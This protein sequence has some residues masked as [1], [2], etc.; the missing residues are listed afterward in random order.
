VLQLTAPERTDFRETTRYEEV[1]SLMRAASEASPLIH[2]T[3]FGYSFEGRSLPLAVVGRVADASPEAVRASGKTVVY[4]QGDIHA[5]EVEGKEV[6]LILL[7]EIAE[8]MHLP[9]LDSIVILVAP[10]LNAD[11]NERVALTNRGAQHGP[12]G[13]TGTRANAQDLN[14]NRDHM[15]LDSPEGR[16]FVR[17]LVDYDPQL[18]ADLHTTNGTE[19]GYHLT[20]APPLHPNTDPSI[21]AIARDRIFPEMTARVRGA[22]GWEFY[23]YG[24]LQG[25]GENRGWATFDYRPRFNNNYLGLRNRI[26]LLSEAYSYAT[27]EDRMTATRHFVHETLRFASAHA[28]EIR[29]LVA[30]ADAASIVGERLAVRAALERSPEPVEILLGRVEEEVN[31]YSGAI[32]RR[33]TDDVRVERM[34]EFGTFGG[35]DWET[36]PRAYYVPS[37]L[38]EV[39]RTLS[40]HGVQWRPVDSGGLGS[41]DSLERF[42]IESVGSGTN[43]FEGRVEQSL[44]GTWEPMDSLPTGEF[45]E[46]PV[47]QPLGRLVFSL[48]EPRSDD[49][50]AHWGFFDS[51]VVGAAYFPVLRSR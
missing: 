19:H 46:V 21:V 47:D 45:L 2:L 23:Y 5:G 42:R 35:T 28:T 44:A 24:N 31:P 50:L 25:Q 48:L 49:G 33:R 20:Y 43:P 39:V 14:I 29:E 18:A 6:L 41:T 17:L 22:T 32:M 1:V 3:S 27:F 7:R 11:G 10:I 36:A 38:G 34:W 16:S 37:D 26:G 30:R 12:I 40:A 4:L 51:S 13:G 15:K 9:L 8:G